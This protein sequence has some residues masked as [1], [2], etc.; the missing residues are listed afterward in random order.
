MSKQ[1]IISCSLNE[2]KESDILDFFDYLKRETHAS[3][4]RIIKDALRCYHQC[5]H[6]QDSE[7][8]EVSPVDYSPPLYI[9]P[10]KEAAKSA[11]TNM[12]LSS[13]QLKI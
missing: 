3:D 8:S 5:Y 13:G 11:I 12:L 7:V 9:Q 2:V 10:N 6:L 4:S 1:R